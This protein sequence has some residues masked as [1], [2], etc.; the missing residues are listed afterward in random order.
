MNIIHFFLCGKYMNINNNSHF[1]Y[2]TLK[3]EDGS[4]EYYRNGL[5]HRDN[6]LPAIVSVNGHKEWYI[7]GVNV[8]KNKSLPVVIY[9]DGMYEY[10]K[11][12]VSRKRIM[13]F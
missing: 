13:S 10:T 8:R 3:Y 4:V 1:I 9:S 11:N 5:L 7:D 2:S 12:N 6:D